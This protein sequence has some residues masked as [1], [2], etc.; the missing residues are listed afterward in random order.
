MD[1]DDLN[2]RVT[3]AI[4]HAESLAP[5]SQ[6]AWHAFHEVGLL[7]ES[8]ATHTRA[9]DLEGEIARLGAVTAALSAGEPLRAVLLAKRYLADNVADDIRLKLQELLAEGDAELARVGSDEPNVAF[10]PFALQNAA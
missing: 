5:G 9:D 6:E 1:I 4:V 2:R 3:N 8:L 7:E 10:V